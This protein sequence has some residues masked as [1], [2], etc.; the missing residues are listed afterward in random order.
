M[1]TIDTIL[2]M[3]TGH[4]GAAQ[5]V[6]RAALRRRHEK[7]RREREFEPVDPEFDEEGLDDLSRRIVEGAGANVDPEQQ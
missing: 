4:S 3:T 2:R 5:A 7:T 1:R 6:I